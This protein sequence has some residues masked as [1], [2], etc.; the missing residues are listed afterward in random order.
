MNQ[1]IND[2][3]FSGARNQLNQN[4]YQSTKDPREKRRIE[5]EDRGIVDVANFDGVTDA[6]KAALL[7]IANVKKG[8]YTKGVVG[9]YPFYAPD[10]RSLKPAPKAS[11]A[12]K[13]LLWMYT[14]TRANADVA[15]IS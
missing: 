6:K 14:A 9:Q 2:L 7:S 8:K 5:M 3:A 15:Q 11:E 4:I 12:D 13:L 1:A 10:T